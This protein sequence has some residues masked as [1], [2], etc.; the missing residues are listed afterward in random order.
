MSLHVA[1][2]HRRLLCGAALAAGLLTAASASAQSYKVT[3]LVTDD[4]SVLA[5]LGYGSAPTTDP[6]L[7]NP[8]D[9]SNSP[10]GPWV[11]ANTGDR[12]LL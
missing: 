1:L 12:D 9:I 10:T 11:I 6:A 3:P 8:W 7:I 5:T 2:D 4:Q